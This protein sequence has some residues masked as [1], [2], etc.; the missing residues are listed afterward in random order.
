[1]LAR[2]VA[3]IA[4]KGIAEFINTT[5]NVDPHVDQKASQVHPIARLDITEEET[6]VKNDSLTRQDKKKTSPTLQSLAWDSS[7][8]MLSL[9]C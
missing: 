6:R 7:L 5:T 1:M 9:R 8:M 2:D 4:T 3:K